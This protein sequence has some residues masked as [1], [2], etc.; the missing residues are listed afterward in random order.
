MQAGWRGKVG[1]AGGV[2]PWDLRGSL[3]AGPVMLAWGPRASL[4]WP[5]LP[6]HLLMGLRG[7]RERCWGHGA[8]GGGS[9]GSGVCQAEAHAPAEGPR[10]S[11]WTPLLECTVEGTE[12]SGAQALGQESRHSCSSRARVGPRGPAPRETGWRLPWAAMEAP[13]EVRRALGSYPQ[14]LCEAR[15]DPHVAGTAAGL[16]LAKWVGCF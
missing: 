8:V 3:W 15:A 4:P 11:R 7:E 12:R 1:D 16:G 6:R 5:P 14:R 10:E 13:A 9:A 2:G